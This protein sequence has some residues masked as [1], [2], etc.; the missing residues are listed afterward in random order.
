[1]RW[2]YR[3]ERIDS[4]GNYASESQYVHHRISDDVPGHYEHRWQP[5][6]A[7]GADGWELVTV[8]WVEGDEGI[9]LF[10][11]PMGGG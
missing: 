8:N 11:R 5:L 9:A 10:K 3:A 4:V 6:D 7:L 1:M 2:Q